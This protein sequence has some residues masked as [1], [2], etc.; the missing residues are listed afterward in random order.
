MK[1]NLNKENNDI[2]TRLTEEDNQSMLEDHIKID[3]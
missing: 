3:Q 2:F 1:M